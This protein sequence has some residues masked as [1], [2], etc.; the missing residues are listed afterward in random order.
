MST[1]PEEILDFWFRKVGAKRW[2]AEDPQLDETITEKF[3][4]TYEKAVKGELKSWEETPEGML[5]LLLLFDTFP[6]RMFRGTAKAF[7]TDDIALDLARTA[8]IN[9]FDDRIDRSFKLFF[10]L[11][12]SHSENQGDQRLAV[13]YIRERTKEPEWVDAAVLNQQIVQC[14]GRFPERNQAL[15]RESTEEEKA[16][17]AQQG[18]KK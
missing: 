15:G 2:F 5:S 18:E 16:Y 4:D 13:Y 1:G 12:F 9:H 17:L 6:R 8:I 10:Y 7:A 14:F 11:P 3:L